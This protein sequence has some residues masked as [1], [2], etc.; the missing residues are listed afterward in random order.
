MKK[1]L[2]FL[3]ACSVCI[4]PLPVAALEMAQPD[5]EMPALSEEETILTS[6]FCG[7]EGN[8][9]NIVWDFD[10]STGT[11]TISGTG[12]MADFDMYNAG[13]GWMR[14]HSPWESF[15]GNI[16]TAIILNGVTNIGTGTFCDCAVTS[17]SIP[18]SVETIGDSAFENCADLTS[19]T[20]PDGVTTIGEYA[21]AYCSGLTSIMI[22]DNVTTIGK[23]AFS[24]CDGLTSVMIPDSVTSIGESAFGECDSLYSIDV[25]ENNP[26]Y[27][28]ENDVL[29]DKDKTILI[30]CFS[31][32]SGTYTIPD[33]VTTI[34]N[35][36]FRDRKGLTSVMIPD[37]VTTI[38]DWAF[39]WCDGLTSVTIPDSITTIGNGAFENCTSLTSV[40][41]PESV[42]EIGNSAFYFC[43]ELTSVIIPENV[44]TIGNFVFAGCSEL[45][46]MEIPDS[47][48]TIGNGTF[49][50]CTGLTSV[51]IP[52]SVTTIG[53]HAFYGCTGLDSVIIPDS[54]TNIREYAF[55]DCAGLTSIAIPENVTSIESHVFSNCVNLSSVMIP[56]SVTTI[57]YGAFENCD[58]LTS[59]TIPDSVQNIGNSAFGN[60]DE[61]T[62]VVIP[63]SVAGIEGY[64]FG[65]CHYLVSITI[66][67]LDCKI[68]DSEYT[69][70][71]SAVIYGYPDSTA[72]TYAEKHN[73]KFVALDNKPEP[74]E[75]TPT[76]E[77]TTTTTTSTTTTTTTATT[78]T[79]T[80]TTTTTA[81]TTTTEISPVPANPT[82]FTEGSNNWC[83]ANSKANFGKN[84]YIS[85]D[86]Q[87]KLLDGLSR[88]ECEDVLDILSGEFG[89]SCYG[90][91]CTSILSCYDI[92]NSTDYQENAHFLH[93]ID[94][95]PSK[96]VQSLINYYF[97]LQVT[98]EVQQYITQALY[99]QTEEEK[100]QQLLEQLED[101]SPVLL[102]FY[103]GFGGGHAVVAYGVEQGKFFIDSKSYD[104]KILIYD[105]NVIDFTD[106][107]CMYINTSKN[108]W[109]IPCYLDA[110]SDKG[111]RIG[112]TT[113][114]LQ[115]IN[116]HGYLGDSKI[117]LP[118]EYIPILSSK[119]ISSDFSLRRIILKDNSWS[120][121]SATD[122]EIK[123]FSS[124]TSK[125]TPADMK[126]A[127]K[128]N[129]EGCVMQLKHPEK[130]DMSMRYANDRIQTN[131][132][133]ADEIVFDPSGYV[134]ISGKTSDYTLNLISN[135]GYAPTDWYKMNASGKAS[136]VTFYKTSDGYIMKADNL[137]NVSLSAKSDNS[138]P[139]LT[140]S[141]EYSEVLI[142]EID[143]NTIGVAVD[144]DENGSYET[145]IAKTEPLK[146]GDADSDGNINILDV[147]LV[148][149]AILG[150]SSLTAEQVKAVDFNRNGYPE[151]EEALMM[152]KYIVGIITDFS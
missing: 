115:I 121:N 23:R 94:A 57:G 78:T 125:N 84:Y 42:T 54:V 93:D 51:S 113:D 108:T 35:Y 74:P 49:E 40:S 61:L 91:A 117:S 150:K 136:E 81:T 73:R 28:S 65:N 15:T 17:V 26:A 82:T 98:D 60:C 135:D 97:A 126:F 145:T 107:A 101:D 21:F 10:E 112:L 111:G 55:A 85:K 37:S 9:E 86:Y 8:E 106:D 45:T 48:T 102:T 149:R 7:A 32:L 99:D 13:T 142:Y 100:I 24:W 1:L 11:L 110:N 146:Q 87:K 95:P 69:I 152:M 31:Q 14:S 76:P 119:A 83:F 75:I 34:G 92:L 127:V 96:E 130:I 138:S 109:T 56:H 143:K 18:D 104:T 4:M 38:E 147:I 77:T 66:E 43:K 59:V 36:A 116:Y 39:L 124:F 29:F 105:N 2:A 79:I 114:N 70:S 20:V 129:Q 120:I 134:E 128:G 123:Q 141:T 50:N 88:T 3:L 58:N 67:N 103:R 137:E 62:S 148:N 122:D 68:D 30:Q 139:S 52:E 27:T 33:G 41:I 140:F 71:D 118:Q 22:S 6:G 53:N 72:Q 133:H 44:T 90:M 144:T 19:F 132:E 46:S 131:F 5:L 12:A 64:A 80:T 63:D 16:S 47:V 89:G 25:D 151:P